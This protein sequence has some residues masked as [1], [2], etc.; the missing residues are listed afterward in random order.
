[1]RIHSN[2]AH[3]AIR[4][5]AFT[6]LEVLV[7]LAVLM[8]IL[9][10]LLPSIDAARTSAKSTKC[11]SNLKQLFTA[12]IC[13]LD[14]SNGW[15]PARANDFQFNYGGKQ[16]TGA[17]QYGRV[18]LN[19]TNPSNPS[20]W[21]KPVSKPLNR[22]LQLDEVV[23]GDAP[24]FQCPADTGGASVPTTN[25]Q[26]YGTSYTMNPLLVGPRALHRPPD[27]PCDVQLFNEIN[28]QLA[29]VNKDK[30]EQPDRLILMGDGG[31][32]ITQDRALPDNIFWHVTRRVENILFLNGRIAPVCIH[33]G[34][35]SNADYRMIPF[36]NLAEV[37]SN[38]QKEIAP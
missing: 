13:L 17:R 14:E 33:K 23:S 38:C 31:W 2:L 35:Y 22:H 29:S 20:S 5:R 36:T 6:M 37:A 34:I 32:V 19:P 8:L 16:G 18:L 9:A 3:R 28:S 21:S 26:F 30:M 7:V 1:M 10:M 24:V 15:F 25:Y 4:R 12:W 11:Q 27:E